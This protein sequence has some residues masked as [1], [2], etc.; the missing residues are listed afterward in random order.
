MEV[1]ACRAVGVQQ[2]VHWKKIG[3]GKSMKCQ[4]YP[5]LTRSNQSLIP[6]PQYH[7]I[8]SYNKVILLEFD[9]HCRAVLRV[10]NPIVSNAQRTR[11]SEVAT[12]Q[13]IWEHWPNGSIHPLP[14]KVIAWDASPDTEVGTPFTLA[15]SADGITANDNWYQPQMQGMPVA[16][17][18]FDAVWFEQLLLSDPFAFHGA[19]YFAEDVN[20]HSP[21]SHC[22]ILSVVCGGTQV[23]S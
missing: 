11:A 17:F 22:T 8:G 20:E 10:P 3:E 5:S 2:I 14:P 23:P 16:N 4:C 1:A 12:I 7:N 13:Y 21:L 18:I 19:L 15:E 6:P 9:N